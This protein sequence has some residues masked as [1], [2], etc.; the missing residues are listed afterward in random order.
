MNTIIVTAYAKAPQNTAIF[1]AYKHIGIVLE[2]DIASRKIVDAEF[3]LITN[4]AKDYF[5]RL[6]VGYNMEDGVG[7]LLKKIE[8]CYFAPSMNSFNVALK[9][10]F[11]RYEER[12]IQCLN[13]K[14]RKKDSI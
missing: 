8:G 14:G 11:R 10:A 6:F 9:S 13:N 4:L 2:I 7:D 12:A 5:K 3:T 1:E